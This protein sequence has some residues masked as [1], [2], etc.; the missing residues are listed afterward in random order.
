MWVQHTQTKTTLKKAKGF[1]NLPVSSSIKF[2]QQ[3]K[4]SIQSTKVKES[5]DFS[6]L[7]YC[8]HFILWYLISYF[9][10]KITGQ[11]QQMLASKYRIMPEYSN[12]MPAMFTS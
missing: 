10:A 1:I 12:G 5:R 7:V 11:L 2:K 9:G 8:T 6:A 4:Q 3:E